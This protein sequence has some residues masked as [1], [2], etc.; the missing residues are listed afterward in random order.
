M[1]W[2]TSITRTKVYTAM[3]V[4]FYTLPISGLAFKIT[5]KF[6]PNLYFRPTYDIEA[7]DI[8]TAPIYFFVFCCLFAFVWILETAILPMMLIKIKPF[9]N[10]TELQQKADIEMKEYL[11]QN[12]FDNRSKKMKP[13]DI[14]SVLCFCF[15]S[16]VLWILY[17]NIEL[18]T[19]LISVAVCLTYLMGK[20]INTASI[21]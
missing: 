15:V 10:K 18:K 8:N 14:Y 12:V 19:V 2:L 7:L 5:L 13:I 3:K 16:F 21:K 20:I 4:L 11:N 17:F 6:C 9:K 1:E